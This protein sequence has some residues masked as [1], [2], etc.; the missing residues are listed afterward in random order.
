LL[1]SICGLSSEFD[2][3]FSTKAISPLIA[4]LFSLES[5]GG[6]VFLL[7]IEKKLP[8]AAITLTIIYSKKLNF[9]LYF[10]SKWKFKFK[11]SI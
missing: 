11:K 9:E 7:L 5:L 6:V 4:K 8:I 10:K 3:G 2:G 1:L